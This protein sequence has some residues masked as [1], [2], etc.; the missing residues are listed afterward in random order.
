MAARP[1]AARLW[2]ALWRA[3]CRLPFAHLAG[4]IC[5]PLHRANGLCMAEGRIGRCMKRAGHGGPHAIYAGGLWTP[6][7]PVEQWT[8]FG[9]P[10]ITRPRPARVG[11][12]DPCHATKIAER[13][14]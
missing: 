9:L 4:A 7:Y 14:A 12:Y 11:P 5:T 10:L 8:G 2:Y 1:L 3:A 6:V 13:P